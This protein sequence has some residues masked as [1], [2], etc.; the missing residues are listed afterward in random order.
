L[1]AIGRI[2]PDLGV[3][4]IQHSWSN[5]RHSSLRA[6]VFKAL[7]RRG[8]ALE[9]FGVFQSTLQ[10]SFPFLFDDFAVTD[11][12]AVEVRLQNLF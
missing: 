8:I 5:G 10:K 4:A 11:Y 12:N 2:R 1:S 9:N 7:R 3:F 6:S